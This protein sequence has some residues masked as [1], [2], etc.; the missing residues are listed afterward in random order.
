MLGKEY[1]LVN[2]KDFT[3]VKD[4]GQK[5]RS[6]NFTLGFLKRKENVDS[7]SHFGIVTTTKMFPRAVD[8]N[9][10][11]RLISEGVR[12]NTVHLKEGYDC[13]FVPNPEITR[14]YTAD[15]IK[16]VFNSLSEAK[17]TKE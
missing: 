13:V 4:L 15:L 16:E 6:K 2:S 5:I 10:I 17:I 12:Q 7:P 14:A 8:R 11:R 3:R 9:R 1:R